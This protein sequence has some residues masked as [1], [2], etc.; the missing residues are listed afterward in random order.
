V[1]I[2][3]GRS[4]NLRQPSRFAHSEL[5]N[6]QAR[7]TIGALSGASA[8]AH[9]ESS[10]TDN[11]AIQATQ[12]IPFHGVM[13]GLTHIVMAEK[14]GL[15]SRLDPSRAYTDFSSPSESILDF[16]IKIAIFL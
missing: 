7:R 13:V 12:T 6:S 15:E 2:N 11:S 16:P 14:E 8:A 1:L 9:L 4:E 5:R 10:N 3:W